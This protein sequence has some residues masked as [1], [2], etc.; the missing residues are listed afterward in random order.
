MALRDEALRLGRGGGGGSLRTARYDRTRS[1]VAWD[2]DDI[3]PVRCRVTEKGILTLVACSC[4][5]G[6]HRDPND[7]SRLRLIAVDEE[8][9]VV[10][11][12]VQIRPEIACQ[13]DGSDEFAQPPHNLRACARVRCDNEDWLGQN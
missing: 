5:Q 4:M 3:R 12:D 10:V 1:A 13:G 7:D 9:K 8:A 2:R 11:V 6:A